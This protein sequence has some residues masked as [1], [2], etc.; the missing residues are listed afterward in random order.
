MVLHAPGLPQRT[1]RCE[2]PPPRTGYGPSSAS[3]PAKGVPRQKPGKLVLQ[4]ENNWPY[5]QGN[6]IIFVF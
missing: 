1:S 5:L 2:L 6:N 4:P 3:D